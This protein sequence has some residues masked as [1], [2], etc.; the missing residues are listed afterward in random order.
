[1]M[2]HVWLLNFISNK[3]LHADKK[4]KDIKNMNNQIRVLSTLT[5]LNGLL[6][7]VATS[8]LA[9]D[10]STDANKCSRIKLCDAAVENTSGKPMWSIRAKDQKYVEAAKKSPRT[11]CGIPDPRDLSFTMTVTK[12]E[13]RSAAIAKL[14]SRFVDYP[15][16]ELYRGKPVLPPPPKK[17]LKAPWIW[18]PLL[19]DGPNF[20]GHYVFQSMSCGTNCS[21][22]RIVDITTGNELLFDYGG[23]EPHYG[24]QKLFDINSSLIKVV[25]NT[26]K[27]YE[28]EFRKCVM[29]DISFLAP[30]EPTI[31]NRFTF[32]LNLDDADLCGD[33]TEWAI[34]TER[35]KDW[36][37]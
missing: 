18:Q 19:T 8:L 16:A 36:N 10:C 17:A 26:G 31:E 23:E 6:F 12:L 25:W 5:I 27:P 22:N 28:G 29:E 20:N 37:K 34:A 13:Q 1:M 24:L 11:N 2:K 30:Q 21:T 32:K 14:Q 15:P 3:N 4:F 35:L 33:T 7:L 9:A